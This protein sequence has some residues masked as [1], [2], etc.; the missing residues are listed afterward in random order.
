MSDDLLQRAPLQHL[1]LGAARIAYRCVGDGP[2]LVLIHGWPFDGTTYGALVTR[3]APH[4]RCYLPDTPGLGVSEWT[5]RT[6]FS[7]PGQAST[8]GR[9]IDALG[10]GSCA[11]LA[12]DTGATIARLLAAREPRRVR[13]LVLLNTEMPGHRPPWIPL[14]R[15]VAALPAATSGF[16]LAMRQPAFIRSR[17]GF[18]GCFHDPARLDTAFVER[19]V[20]PL[21]RSPGRVAGTLRYLRGIDWAVIDGLVDTHRRIECEVLLVWGAGDR[22]FPVSYARRLP[23]QF[24]HC[25]GLVEVADACF[26]VHEERPDEVAAAALRFLT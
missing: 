7:L 24:R 22:T 18:G 13:K 23:E 9:V 20:A 8:I 4:F 5:A 6:D 16:A 12:H 10:L 14:Y 21:T 26:L 1:D 15:R 19:V 11:I 25:A 17:L 2:P 3:L